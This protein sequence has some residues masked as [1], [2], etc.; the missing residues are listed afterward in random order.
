M[1]SSF[2]LDLDIIRIMGIINPET[3]AQEYEHESLN[4]SVVT[5]EDLDHPNRNLPTPS[6]R[7][8]KL[9]YIAETYEV[10]TE[11]GYILQ[12]HRILGSKKSP[13][14]NDKPPVL[15]VHGLLDCSASWVL[16]SPEKGLGYMLAD[17]GYDV[18]MGNV[19]GNRYSRKHKQYTTAD[20][21][22]WMFSWHEIGMF[23][24]PAMIDH[25]LKETKREKILY[26][27]HSQGSTSF[28]VMASERPEYQQK[29]VAS[30]NMAPAVFMSQA[31][32]PFICLLSPIVNDLNALMSMIGKNEFKPSGPFI[33]TVAKII[34]D[35]DAPTQPICTNVMTLF[36]GRN[37]KELNY[38]LLPD[39]GQYDP[40]GASIRQFT[41]YAQLQTSGNFEQFN[42]GPVDNMIKY[43]SINP[44]KYDLA[45]IKMPVYLFYGNNDE[46]V[47]V[48]DLNELYRKL[49][50]AKK[51]LVPYKWFTHLDFLWA[52]N[53]D[54]LVYNNMLDLMAKYKI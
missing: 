4:G 9:G 33:R 35:D 27:G 11:D 54:T 3:I 29:L 32:H 41:H 26:V 37:E 24:I 42:Y 44:P 25:V 22:Y 38:T 5:F 2:V 49:P 31:T 15:L 34:C 18:W 50:N 8:Q 7:A 30:F 51:F 52:M 17:Q 1:Q 28:F 40:A 36:G 20:K 16:A 19:R 43:G 47:S 21:N 12:M 14:S 46:M 6:Q 53:I 45:S 48:M 10:V 39:I 13:K 23:D